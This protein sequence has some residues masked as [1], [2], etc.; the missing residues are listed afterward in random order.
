MFTKL[1][2]IKMVARSFLGLF[3]NFTRIFPEEVL[4]ASASFI[5]VEERE[6]KA[7]SAPDIRAEQA[8]RQKRA[9]GL[10]TDMPAT[11]KAIISKPGGSVSKCLKFS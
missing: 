6:K 3:N 10:I 1:L 8:S 7:T 2:A 5:S 11:V 9:M 4:D